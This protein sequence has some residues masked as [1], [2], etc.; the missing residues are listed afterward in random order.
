VEGH[1][2]YILSAASFPVR[3]K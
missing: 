1:K 3:L 2:L